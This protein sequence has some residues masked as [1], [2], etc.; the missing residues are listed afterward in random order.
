MSDQRMP[1]LCLC[2]LFTVACAGDIKGEKGDPGDPVSSTALLKRPDYRSSGGETTVVRVPAAVDQPAK[3]FIA[4]RLLVNT[5]DRTAGF[6]TSGRNGLDSGSTLR[7]ASVYYL[8]PPSR[9]RNKPQ[10]HEARNHS[11][12]QRKTILAAH[13]QSLQRPV[14]P[15]RHPPPQAAACKDFQS[16]NY[17]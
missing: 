10:T 14:R 4:D 9:D 5:E 12:P 17:N 3:V 15:P 7:K 1:L 11:H 6:A 8:G 2:V 16:F 13:S